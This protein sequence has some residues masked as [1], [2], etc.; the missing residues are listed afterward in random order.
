MEPFV[1]RGRFPGRAVVIHGAQ[2]LETAVIEQHAKAPAHWVALSVGKHRTS[3]RDELILK[4]VNTGSDCELQHHTVLRNVEVDP[5]RSSVTIDHLS[6]N[7]VAVSWDT[8]RVARLIDCD[9]GAVAV[10]QQHLSE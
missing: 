4:W 5:L 10:I 2:L 6:N 9:L 7:L 8:I 1:A 3:R